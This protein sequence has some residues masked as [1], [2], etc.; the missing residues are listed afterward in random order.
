MLL[1]WWDS[2]KMKK[3]HGR[4]DNFKLSYDWYHFRPLLAVVGQYLPLNYGIRSR[5]PGYNRS[6]LSWRPT[7]HAL[8]AWYSISSIFYGSHQCN[9]S[10]Y[11]TC[12]NESVSWD[13]LGY[14]LHFAQNFYMNLDFTK[15]FF[16]FFNRCLWAWSQIVGFTKHASPSLQKK[17]LYLWI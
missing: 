6:L 8:F 16:P 11:T 14:K 3:E 7:P 12:L 9:S 17:T 5:S 4:P 2:I 1:L 13:G 10:V 15:G